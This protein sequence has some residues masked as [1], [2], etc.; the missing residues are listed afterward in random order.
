VGVTPVDYYRITGT[1]AFP[2]QILGIMLVAPWYYQHHTT[3][4]DGISADAEELCPVDIRATKSTLN[5]Q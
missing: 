3:A 5:F 4:L 1:P 2:A